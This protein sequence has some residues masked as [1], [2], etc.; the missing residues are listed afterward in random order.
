M[1][2]VMGNVHSFESFGTLDGPGLRF[3]VFLQG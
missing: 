2:E 3:I 1:S